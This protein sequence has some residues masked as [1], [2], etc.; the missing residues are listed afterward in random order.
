MRG[1]LCCKRKKNSYFRT[2][3][4]TFLFTSMLCNVFDDDDDDDDDDDGMAKKRK[5]SQVLILSPFVHLKIVLRK[6]KQ[7]CWLLERQ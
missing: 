7:D 4:S 1:R 6:K 5:K 2:Q 3:A